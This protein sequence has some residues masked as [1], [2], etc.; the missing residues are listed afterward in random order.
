[1][2]TF[3][4]TAQRYHG[5]VY[6]YHPFVPNS[7]HKEVSVIL[8]ILNGLYVFFSKGITGIGN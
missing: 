1:M 3:T 5:I 6:N 2:E 4:N 7:L 8:K